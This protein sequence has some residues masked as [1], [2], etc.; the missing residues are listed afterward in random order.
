MLSV[1]CLLARV[2]LGDYCTDLST[3]IMSASTTTTTTNYQSPKLQEEENDSIDDNVPSPARSRRRSAGILSSLILVVLGCCLLAMSGGIQT[4]SFSR[5]RLADATHVDTK[6]TTNKAA[7]HNVTFDKRDNSG[8]M[9]APATSDR[10]QSQ[11]HQRRPRERDAI[12]G[13]PVPHRARRHLPADPQLGSRRRWPTRSWPKSASGPLPLRLPVGSPARLPRVPWCSRV[14]TRLA[15][16]E[17][18]SFSMTL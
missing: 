12:R 11:R 10:T 14:W 6:T 5:A 16:S 2:T 7:F 9:N 13:A 1:A 4:A 8:T 18:P 17:W 3:I 15:L